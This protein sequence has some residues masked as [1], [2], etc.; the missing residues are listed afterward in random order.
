MSKDDTKVK[1][2]FEKACT[3]IKSATDLD[4]E[5]LLSLYG[6]YKQATDGD[7]SIAKPGFFDPKGSAKWTAWNENKGMDKQTA[8]RRYVRK[9][10]KIL[11]Q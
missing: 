8:M 7:C 11:E 10:S 2:E 4:N 9:V 5:T 6:L 3:N 1:A